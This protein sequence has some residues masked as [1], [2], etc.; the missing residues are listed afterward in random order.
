MS[1]DKKLA[2]AIADAAIDLADGAGA[3]QRK[4]A[5]LRRMR[6]ALDHRFDLSDVRSPDETPR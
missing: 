6:R 1:D 2:L 3:D 5:D 4:V